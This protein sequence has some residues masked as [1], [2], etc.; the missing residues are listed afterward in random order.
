MAGTLTIH[1]G[2][3]GTGKS[4]FAVNDVILPAVREHRPFFTNITG[5]SLSGLYAVTDIHQSAIRYYPV[6]DINDVIRYFDDAELCAHGVFILDEMKDFIDNEKAVSWL[7]SRIN[8]MRKQTVDFVLI[9][10][11]PEKEYIH[12]H[13]V[14]LA[15]SCNVAVS[16]KRYGDT[17]H[18]D[19]YYVDGG[20]PRI[21]NKIPTNAAGKK[22]RKKPVEVFSCYKTSENKFY[23]GEEDKTYRGLMWWQTRTAKLRFLLVGLFA[24]V[25]LMFVWLGMVFKDIVWGEKKTKAET[26][27]ETGG[28]HEKKSRSDAVASSLDSTE[29]AA[30]R[31]YSASRLFPA[32][33]PSC[34]AWKVCVD[35]FCRTDVGIFQVAPSDSVSYRLCDA[36]K[37]CF[38]PC[39]D[40]TGLSSGR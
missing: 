36:G 5:I 34:Y 29:R 32:A 3:P 31:K 17:T 16:R 7:E 8:V 39:K 13:I 9:A 10:Q 22:V 26:T 33:G 20:R 38:E 19:W 2:L 37:R 28:N 1:Y 25:V 14:E 35:G 18:V 11:L 6:K 21:V 4:L 23:T 40:D 30:M 15:D 24:V 27:L 12:P